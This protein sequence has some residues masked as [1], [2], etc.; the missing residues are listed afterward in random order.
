MTFALIEQQR[1]DGRLEF[2]QKLEPIKLYIAKDKPCLLNF[3]YPIK[4]HF[5]TDPKSFT[6]KAGFNQLFTDDSIV[7]TANNTGVKT[8]LFVELETRKFKKRA[9]HFIEII[10]DQNKAED[11][12]DISPCTDVHYTENG[13]KVYHGIDNDRFFN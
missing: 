1:V 5:F 10:E 13:I 4:S 7:I 12:Y 9:C 8:Y 3:D 2:H 11:K 6:I